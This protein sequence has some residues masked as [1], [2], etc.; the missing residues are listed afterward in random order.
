MVLSPTMATT[1]SISLGLWAS[2][3]GMV[4]ISNNV[5]VHIFLRFSRIDFIDF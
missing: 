5:A 4:M 3:A 1:W 2:D